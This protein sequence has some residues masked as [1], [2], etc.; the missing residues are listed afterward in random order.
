[1]P[2]DKI[3][4]IFKYRWQEISEIVNRDRETQKLN[5]KLQFLAG[6]PTPLNTNRLDSGSD[7]LSRRQRRPASRRLRHR[8]RGWQPAEYMP[9]AARVYI[10]GRG[11]WQGGVAAVQTAAA[12]V[13]HKRRWPS[14]PPPPPK[15]T[16]PSTRLP[17]S[18][19]QRHSGKTSSTTLLRQEDLIES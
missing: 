14:K 12:A 18:S 9:G 3:T 17:P 4:G 5:D 1:M 11:P 13:C 10:D 8:Q 2:W 15:R 16:P 19:R 6:S 7:Q